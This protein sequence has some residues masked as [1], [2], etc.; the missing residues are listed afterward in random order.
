MQE[1]RWKVLPEPDR[2]ICDRL[3]RELT[4]A[5][6]LACLLGQ[7]GIDSYDA[8]RAFF[9]PDLSMLHDPFLLKDMDK[10]VD[11]ITTAVSSG[12][13]IMI[14]GDYDVD[15]TTSVAMM[16]HFLSSFYDNCI[17]YI[18]DR[19]SEGYG[20]SE[21]GVLE[22]IR[23]NTGLIITLDCGIKSNRLVALAKKEGIDFIICDHHRPGT[24]L[25]DAVAVLDPKR[26][27]CAYPYK[28]LSGCGV[29]FKL[30][31]AMVV[32]NPGI[33]AH[34]YDYLDL[35]AVSIGADIV[36]VTG[37]NRILAFF[38]LRALED[39]P[40]PGLRALMKYGNM[41]EVN[42]TN[43]VFRIA[44]RIN[45]A[46]RIDHAHEAV[47]LLLADSAS[48]AEA[49][50]ARLQIQNQDRKNT[51]ELI[52]REA[53][54]M[55]ESDSTMMSARSTVLFKQD[56]HKGVI[57]I[58]ASR[59]IEKYYR[60]TIIL[61]R[62]EGDLVTGSARSVNGFDVY[63]ALTSCAELLEQYGGHMYAA[64]MT[65]RE[66][67]IVAFREEF[68]R[69]V[70]S[71]I[72]EEQLVPE[73]TVDTG[74]IFEEITPKFYRI[75]RQMAPFGPENLMPVFTSEGLKAQNVTILKERHLKMRV[76][77]E[78]SGKSFD[79]IGFGL[80]DLAPLVKSQKT[81]R[82]AYSLEENHFRG[83]TSLQMMIKDI[84]AE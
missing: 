32:C 26:D 14:Y 51:D 22:A 27:D 62:K 23:Q 65:L 68:E 63:N 54:E 55:I 53:L 18:P 80:S 21:A 40:R 48:E 44:P 13:K 43:V 1:K 12:E 36:P 25:P 7:R 83:K 39:N 42:M 30:I 8:A 16:F 37:E 71:T 5:R 2:H 29:G 59:C 35:L 61:T 9:R 3:R 76:V 33:P 49:H 50:A 78:A 72:H 81:F 56:W 66:E 31:Q 73:I 79:A 84:K 52:T 17:Y 24:E 57:G 19:H 28:E 10:A 38:G 64:G 82:M 15:G 67:N 74:L 75:L 47:R 58:V 6:P 41:Q 45:S 34:P 69:V 11:R 77:Q 70:A 4:I 60:P 20:V 46:G